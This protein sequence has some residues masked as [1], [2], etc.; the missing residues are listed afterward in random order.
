MILKKDLNKLVCFSIFLISSS[1]IIGYN[2]ISEEIINKL[3]NNFKLINNQHPNKFDSSIHLLEISTQRIN[4]LFDILHEKEKRYGEVLSS[5]GLPLFDNLIKKKQQPVLDNFTLEEI[6]YLK[7]VDNRVRA[8]DQ[9][10]NFLYNVSS[11]SSP[12][13]KKD[14]PKKQ[15]V[16]INDRPVVVTASNSKYYGS[17]QNTI[18]H[19]H[20]NLPGYEII[21][22][23]LGLNDNEYK[24]VE[25]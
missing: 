16:P 4:K 2:T 13:Y 1:F 25:I 9:F 6:L 18:Y 5:L 21:V 24:M 11:L 8:T 17:L 14:R 12:R 15:K 3:Y 10:V 19:L 22:Y 20:E 23:D 7:V